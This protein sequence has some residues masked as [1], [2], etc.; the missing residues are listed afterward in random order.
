MNIIKP[1]VYAAGHFATAL[2]G[3][4]IVGS[5]IGNVTQHLQSSLS[6]GA[7]CPTVASLGRAWRLSVHQRRQR[8]AP[9]GLRVLGR[10]CL[11]WRSSVVFIAQ[12]AP[13]AAVWSGI[14]APSITTYTAPRLVPKLTG[15]TVCNSMGHERVDRE[16][17]CMC[18]L[19]RLGA[20]VCEALNAKKFGAASASSSAVAADAVFERRCCEVRESCNLQAMLPSQSTM[21]NVRIFLNYDMEV[22]TNRVRHTFLW[23]KPEPTELWS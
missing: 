5:S 22:T 21:Y 8:Y 15:S 19:C 18:M 4:Y 3:L 9:C 12:P 17:R 16:S 20:Q 23:M 1:Q 13:R 6:N 7:N 14:S 11:L 10:V 2:R